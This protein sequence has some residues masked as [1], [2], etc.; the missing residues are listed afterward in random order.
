[1]QKVNEEIVFE[2]KRLTT[3]YTVCVCMCLYCID[4]LIILYK[5]LM[6]YHMYTHPKF[7]IGKYPN[8][9]QV[10]LNFCNERLKA[11]IN[12]TCHCQH[13]LWGNCSK[14]QQV[15]Q[16]VYAVWENEK[17]FGMCVQNKVDKKFICTK[18]T[19]FCFYD[20]NQFY[21]V[22]SEKQHF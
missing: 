22:L 3:A 7:H 13:H 12:F 20:Q 15:M 10:L 2:I 1:M 11:V 16:Y 19:S 4:T 8:L 6:S 5:S 14:K 17:C 18:Y 9:S 21:R